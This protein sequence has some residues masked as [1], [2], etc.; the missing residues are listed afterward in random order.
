MVTRSNWIG[1]LQTT[2]LRSKLL[3]KMLWLRFILMA[4]YNNNNCYCYHCYNTNS[5][6]GYLLF[7]LAQRFQNQTTIEGLNQ[8]NHLTTT[9]TTRWTYIYKITSINCTKTGRTVNVRISRKTTRNANWYVDISS[10]AGRT[11]G[12]RI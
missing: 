7:L 5:I 4:I 6:N 12:V 11:E 1:T 10:I 2:K 3:C 9:T 8:I